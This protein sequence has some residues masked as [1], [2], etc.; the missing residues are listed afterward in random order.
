[1]EDD[2]VIPDDLV[3]DGECEGVAVMVRECAGKCCECCK[4]VLCVLQGEA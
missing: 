2:V 4:V 1:M 3:E